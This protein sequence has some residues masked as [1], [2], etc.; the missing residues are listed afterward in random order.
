MRVRHARSRALLALALGLLSV[1][2]L[3]SVTAAP[4]E[5]AAGPFYWIVNVKT[6]RVLMPYDHSQ[7]FYAPIVANLKGSGGAQHWEVKGAGNRRYFKNRHSHLCIMISLNNNEFLRQYDCGESADAPTQPHAY[8]TRE[9]WRPSSVDDMWAG[10]TIT[11]S[12]LYAGCMAVS[13]VA[14]IGTTCDSSSTAQQFRLEYVP[15]T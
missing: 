4:A 15:G 10:R 1:L 5:A 9:T 14:A 6:G 2:G 8:V 13:G 3:V 11:L 12:S 7:S